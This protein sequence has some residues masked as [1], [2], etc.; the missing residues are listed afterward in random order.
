M[1]LPQPTRKQRA[2][3]LIMVSLP[4]T[5][6]WW[7]KLANQCHRRMALTKLSSTIIAPPRSVRPRR[8]SALA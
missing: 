5:L 4:P 2:I 3:M 6:S 1:R 8:H 7:L